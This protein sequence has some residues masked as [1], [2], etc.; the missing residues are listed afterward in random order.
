MA[1]VV[2]AVASFSVAVKAVAV[3]QVISRDEISRNALAFAVTTVVS[4]EEFVMVVV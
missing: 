3:A 2:P 4:A 1:R